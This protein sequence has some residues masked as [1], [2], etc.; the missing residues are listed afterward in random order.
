MPV[1][2]IALYVAFPKPCRNIGTTSAGAATLSP[3]ALHFVLLGGGEGT[4]GTQV[5]GGVSALE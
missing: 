4:D 5:Q 2:W 1:T 3:R